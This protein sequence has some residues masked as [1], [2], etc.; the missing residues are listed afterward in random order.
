MG[1]ELSTFWLR[2]RDIQVEEDVEKSQ[3]IK[4]AVDSY[5]FVMMRLKGDTHDKTEPM[6]YA[7]RQTHK[8]IHRMPACLWKILEELVV[9]KGIRHQKPVFEIYVSE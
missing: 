6:N 2:S 3:I 7:F 5:N 9:T 1:L 8:D 4:S